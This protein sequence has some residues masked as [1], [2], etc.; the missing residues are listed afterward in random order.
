MATQE[1]P[2]PQAPRWSPE[3]T[4][5]T[6]VQLEQPQSMARAHLCLK[7]HDG[8]FGLIV[9]TDLVARRWIVTDRDSGDAINFPTA[10]LLVAAG[11]AI[12]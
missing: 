1:F 7:N 11:W 3:L 8:R 5:M 6:R 10:H 12:D 2:A 9:M 4:D